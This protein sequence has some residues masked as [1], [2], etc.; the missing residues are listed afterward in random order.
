MLHVSEENRTLHYFE[1]DICWWG[2]KILA[3]KENDKCDENGENGNTRGFCSWNEAQ[4]IYLL[5]P[6]RRRVLIIYQ[7]CKFRLVRRYK[8]DNE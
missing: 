3:Q 1:G 4:Y 8:Q 7:T 2:G 5:F 6:I